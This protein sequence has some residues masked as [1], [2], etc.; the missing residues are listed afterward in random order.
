MTTSLQ[1]VSAG[2]LG[3]IALLALSGIDARA[4]GAVGVTA[5]CPATGPG[6]V[7]CGTVGVLLHEIVQIANGKDGF[8]PNGEIMKVLAAPVKIVDGNVRAT[9]HERGEIAKVLRATTGISVEDIRKYGVF[10]GPNSIFRK[11]F[12]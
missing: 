7:V 12:G 1:K 10:G 4:D 11:P 9:A 6:I 3:G 8:G 2:L 5:T